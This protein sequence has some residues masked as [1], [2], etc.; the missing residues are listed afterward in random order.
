MESSLPAPTDGIADGV[1]PTIDTDLS[2]GSAVVTVGHG[3]GSIYTF[4]SLMG[5]TTYYFQIWAYSNVGNR[6]DYLT[7]TEGPEASVTTEDPPFVF[8]EEGF[9]TDGHPSRYRASPNGG[10]HGGNDAHFQRTDGS[11][12]DIHSADA[13]SGVSGMYFWAAEQTGSGND[14]SNTEQTIVFN[15]LNIAGFTGLM[16][17]G[18]FGAGNQSPPT[19][20]PPGGNPTFSYDAGEYIRVSYE[21]DDSGTETDVLCFRYE[22]HGDG[23]NEPLGLDADCDGTA[24]NTDGT[25][26]LNTTLAAYSAIIPETGN[27]LTVRIRVRADG[28]GEEMAFDDIKVAGLP[29]ENPQPD[30]HPATFTATATGLGQIDLSWSDATGTNVPTGYVI[31]ANT[32]ESSLPAPIDGVP[33]TIDDDL[34]D[35]S[36]VV[37]VG[38]GTGSRYT[39]TGLT[40]S[41]IYHFQVWAYAN[42]GN[43]ID[44]LLSPEGPA[45][46][47]VTQSLLL[48]EGFETNGHPS[49]YTASSN[50]GFSTSANNHFNRTDGM[51]LDLH[52]GRYNRLLGHALLGRRE[53][54][55][56]RWRWQCCTDHNI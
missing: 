51:G 31:Y 17:S 18:L 47:V 30:N 28:P 38:H 45:V 37:T 3:A 40:A 36:V 13:Y 42:A 9:E 16:V 39:F 7:S 25:D 26:R 46:S 8:F 34:S 56:W 5:S 4:T 24:D 20:T 11:N 21:I 52:S 29:P 32:V 1:P 19:P 10:F 50:G 41:T 55:R 6:I 53:Y 33:P 43:R 2:D 23:G 22:Y 15:D 49:R 54:R 35:G 48:N 44:Y 14:N 27:F 12:I